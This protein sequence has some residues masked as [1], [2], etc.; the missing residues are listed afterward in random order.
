MFYFQ[1]TY[2]AYAGSLSLRGDSIQLTAD[3]GL[4]VH[5][6]LSKGVCSLNVCGVTGINASVA[7]VLF[8]KDPPSFAEVLLLVK[9]AYNVFSIGANLADK[10]RSLIV[11]SRHNRKMKT[12]EGVYYSI[13]LR[14]GKNGSG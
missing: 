5:D 1:A 11:T 10:A 3:L 2:G 13:K 8:D 12:E 7:E 9:R 14:K 6:D 4:L